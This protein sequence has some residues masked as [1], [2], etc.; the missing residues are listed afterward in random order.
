MMQRLAFVLLATALVAG[1]AM[2]IV[3]DGVLDGDYGAARAVQLVQTQFGDNDG[4]GNGGGELNAAYAKVEA[5]RLYVLLTGNIEH[6]FNKLNIFIDSKAGGENVLSATPDYDFN[7]G[8]G[9][10]SSNY[11]G[12]TFDSGFE[13][14]YHLFARLGNTAGVSNQLEVDL[15]DRAGGGSAAVSGDGAGTGGSGPMQAGVIAPG[16]GGNNTAS[17]IS[18]NVEFALDNTNSAGVMG[19]TG[20]ADQAAALAVTTGFEFSVALADIGNPSLGDIKIHAAY[21]NGDHN[22]HS[23]QIL[24]GLPAG[25]GNL[26]GDGAG[27]FTGTLAGVDFNQFAGNQY[28]T[29]PE[30]AGLGLMSL[31]VLGLFI[32]RR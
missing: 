32:R 31:A 1:D 13:A 16:S 27:N 8:G 10:I 15:I 6:S 21:G 11:G 19:G 22:F 9:W 26:G 7:P 28:F 14:D 23:N 24:G 12:L 18:E 4:T 17:F 2:A 25:T 5:D 29:V 3:V 20:P 30:P